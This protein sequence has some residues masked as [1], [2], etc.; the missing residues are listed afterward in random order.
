MAG[1]LFLMVLSLREDAIHSELAQRVA[2]SAATHGIGVIFGAYLVC[3]VLKDDE[4]FV[5]DLLANTRNPLIFLITSHPLEND[6]MEVFKQQLDVWQGA[7][8]SKASIIK[9]LQE[10]L[11]IDVIEGSVAV[12]WD[13]MVPDYH[14]MPAYGV[15]S[16]Q[17]VESIRNYYKNQV[18]GPEGLF[19]IRPVEARQ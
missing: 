13:S 3:Y 9:F 19:R 15:D 6:V 5:H 2:R 16:R 18:G 17:F 10:I 8:P 1:P 11:S 7:D 14:R 4:K 12:I